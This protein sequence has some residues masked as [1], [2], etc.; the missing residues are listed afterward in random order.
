VRLARYH[1]SALYTVPVANAKPPPALSLLTD[2]LNVSCL[3]PHVGGLEAADE[4]LGINE[5]DC[6]FVK[7][8]DA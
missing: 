1:L 5:P 7:P 4:S 2:N 3:A 6:I 8:L